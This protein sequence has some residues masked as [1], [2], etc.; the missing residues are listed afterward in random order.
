MRRRSASCEAGLKAHTP[1]LRRNRPPTWQ[2]AA[3][4]RMRTGMPG[5]LATDEADVTYDLDWMRSLPAND[6]RA[7]PM[8]RR[9]LAEEQ[10]LLDRHF[11]HMQLEALLHRS[12]DTFASALD[13]YDQV[14]SQHDRENGHDPGRIHGEVESRSG[15]GHISADGHPPAEGQRFLKGAVVGRA[16]S[17]LVRSRLRPARSRGRPPTPG[18]C[19]QIKASGHVSKPR[20][21]RQHQRKRLHGSACQV[22]TTATAPDAGRPA[23]GGA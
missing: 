4:S 5:A 10:D 8:L 18:G 21:R 17:S 14:C 2:A 15:A 11:M 23:R 7:I 13:E 19:L 22:R 12:R 3:G 6:I 9:L 16:R 1:Q 20:L